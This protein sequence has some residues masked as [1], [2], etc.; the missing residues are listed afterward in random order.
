MHVYNSVYAYAHGVLFTAPADKTKFKIV[1]VNCNARGIKRYCHF[2]SQTHSSSLHFYIFLTTRYILWC[3][4]YLLHACRTQ[5]AN[6]YIVFTYARTRD[7]KK[8]LQLSNDNSSSQ[9]WLLSLYTFKG[10]YRYYPL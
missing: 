3:I 7:V 2:V 8:N 4:V 10:V 6:V 5:Y 1:R 9:D